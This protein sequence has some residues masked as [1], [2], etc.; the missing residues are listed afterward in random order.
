MAAGISAKSQEPMFLIFLEIDGVLIKR[1]YE[2]NMKVDDQIRELRKSCL[3]YPNNLLI[4]RAA[5]RCFSKTAVDNLM[6]LIEKVSK[7]AQIG[8]VI[9]SSWREEISLED[10]QNH[11]FAD[12]PFGHLIIGKTFDSDF[13]YQMA[14]SE[15]I[16]NLEEETPSQIS[17]RKYG[18]SLAENGVGDI[19]DREIDFWL[20]ENHENLPIKSFVII[21][22]EDSDI[23]ARYPGN[24]VYADQE[25]LFSES[26]AEQAK[27]I[28]IKGHFSPSLFPSEQE[29]EARRKEA[30]K[31]KTENDFQFFEGEL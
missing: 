10:M 22:S 15:G 28:L 25:T 19:K 27:D 20:R 30:E 24:F 3:E 11:M 23:S 18:F 2:T 1:D 21:D 12:T 6:T 9:S 16:A 17:S 8:I 7:V 13:T 29:V 4:K 26:N 14:K 31:F 5:T